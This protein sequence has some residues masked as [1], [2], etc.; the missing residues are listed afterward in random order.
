MA[1]KLYVVYDPFCCECSLADGK[2]RD[3]IDCLCG[4]FNKAKETRNSDVK[5]IIK[6]SNYYALVYIQVKI[7]KEI[8][9]ADE[10]YFSYGPDQGKEDSVEYQLNQKGW[11][12]DMAKVPYWWDNDIY[13]D[14]T[15]ELL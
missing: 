11:H 9:D 1:H 5:F 7:R 14:I 6:I 15:W 8:L 4:D 12:K 13:E 2:I 10:V 3:T